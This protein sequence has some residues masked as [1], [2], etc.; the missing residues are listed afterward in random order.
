M[1]LPEGINLE[2]F[3]NSILEFFQKLFAGI[4]A[5]FASLKVVN[6]YEK[7]EYLP[8]TTVAAE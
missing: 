4:E 8:E 2:E 3:V 7:E 6:G 1:T 5:A